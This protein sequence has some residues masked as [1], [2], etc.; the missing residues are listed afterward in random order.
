MYKTKTSKNSKMKKVRRNEVRFRKKAAA[1]LSS[2][3]IAARD[4]K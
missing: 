4:V 1:R 2:E 3:P